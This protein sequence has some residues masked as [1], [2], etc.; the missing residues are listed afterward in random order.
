MLWR[1]MTLKPDLDLWKREAR[2]VY[3]YHDGLRRVVKVGFEWRPDVRYNVDSPW[4]PAGTFQSG[5]AHHYSTL[6]IAQ[7]AA[8]KA[9]IYP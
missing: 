4:K 1:N 7:Q 2:G 6:T 8:L 9:V 5:G 3:V